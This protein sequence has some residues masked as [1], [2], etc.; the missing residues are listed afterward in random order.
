MGFSH[1]TWDRVLALIYVEFGQVRLSGLQWWSLG[2]AVSEAQEAPQLYL[3]A[4]KD[5]QGASA[6]TVI[7]AWKKAHGRGLLE[8]DKRAGVLYDLHETGFKRLRLY[9][10]VLAW[11]NSRTQVV[12]QRYLSLQHERRLTVGVY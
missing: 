2:S 3:H 7:K 4:R 6:D 9:L 12:S 1:L 10:L 11:C 8:V 5:T